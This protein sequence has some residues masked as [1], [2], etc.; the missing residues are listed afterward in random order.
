M[1]QCTYRDFAFEAL[2]QKVSS[3]KFILTVSR[4]KWNA[5]PKLNYGTLVAGADTL[6]MVRIVPTDT[7]TRGLHM[8]IEFYGRPSND[9]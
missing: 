8:C 1:K 2:V 5:M 6:E 9:H 4:R 7:S 3:S